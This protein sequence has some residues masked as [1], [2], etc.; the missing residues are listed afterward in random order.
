LV[1]SARAAPSSGARAA[2]LEACG[3]INRAGARQQIN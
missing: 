2:S 1:I 3:G